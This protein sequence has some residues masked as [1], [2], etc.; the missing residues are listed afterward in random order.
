[1]GAARAV[2]GR[3]RMSITMDQAPENG[4]TLDYKEQVARIDRT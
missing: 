4:A 3:T 2:P 1:M